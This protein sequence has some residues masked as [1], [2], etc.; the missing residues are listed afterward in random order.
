M[1][2]IEKS[3]GLKLSIV[4]ENE[5]EGKCIYV[6]QTAYAKTA[7]AVGSSKENWIIKMHEGNLILTGGKEKRDRG[8]I[9][10]VY[11]F[12]EDIVGVFMLLVNKFRV[13]SMKVF[14]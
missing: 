6:G 14:L 12:L 10:A 8:I 13:E 1:C 9:Y 11:H 4:S 5:A 7:G 2:Y 3:L